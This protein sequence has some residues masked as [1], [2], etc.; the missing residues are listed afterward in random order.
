M[1]AIMRGLQRAETAAAAVVVVAEVGET[2]HGWPQA[3][4]AAAALVSR[5]AAARPLGP[6][7]RW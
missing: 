4:T 6:P 1:E 7:H 3:E 5:S 2:T